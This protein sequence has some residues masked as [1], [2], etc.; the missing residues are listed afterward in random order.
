MVL[1]MYVGEGDREDPGNYRDITSLNLLGKLY[2]KVIYNSL[3][4]YR[5]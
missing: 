4:K 1:Y 3:L 2:S 5:S